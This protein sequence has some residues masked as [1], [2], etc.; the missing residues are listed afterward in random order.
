MN[1][2]ITIL[3]IT[4]TILVLFTTGATITNY[5]TTNTTTQP[6][7][8]VKEINP[9]ELE[10]EFTRIANLPYGEYQCRQKSDLLKTY[11]HE[12][13]NKYDIYTVSVV[14][15]TN[16]YSHVYVLFNNRVYDPTSIPPLYNKSQERYQVQLEAWGFNT[17][18]T[19]MNGYD[20]VWSD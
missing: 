15:N 17:H 7:E 8:V 9:T 19:V 3:V 14:H 20:G 18:H 10:K 13:Q 4:I 5:T 11:I 1:I 6:I 12:H 16:Q 2:K